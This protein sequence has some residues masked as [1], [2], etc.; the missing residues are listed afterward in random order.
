METGCPLKMLM[1]VN[2]QLEREGTKV[3]L[4]E[5]GEAEG[6]SVLASSCSLFQNGLTDKFG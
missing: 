6:L 1:M 4:G 2:P 3:S 5:R